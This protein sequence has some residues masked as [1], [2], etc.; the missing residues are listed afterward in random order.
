MMNSHDQFTDDIGAYLLGA[1]EPAEERSFEQHLEGCDEC[2]HEVMRLEVA[3]DALPRSVD[4]VAP[5]ERLKQSLME[6]VKAEAPAE[7]AA[8]EPAEPVAPPGRLRD[9]VA[10]GSTRRPRRAR[11]RELLLARPAFAAAAAA[12]LLAV[13]IGLGALAGG[14]GGGGDDSSTVAATVDVTRMPAG[15]ASLV[16]PESKDGALLRVEGM[17]QPQ[18]GHVYEVWIQHDGKVTPSSLFTVDSDGNGTAGIP[19][20]LKGADAVLVTREPMGGSKRPSEPPVVTV[21]LS[22]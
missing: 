11:W 19:E 13:G 2:R 6:T 14:V 8:V 9:A 10:S 3:R 22:S 18:A 20:E 4:Q 17:Q 7:S 1:L 5:P 21:P 12:V 16:V 15:Q